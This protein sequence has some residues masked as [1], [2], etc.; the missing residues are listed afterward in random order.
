MPFTKAAELKKEYTDRINS[1]NKDTANELKQKQKDI[2]GEKDKEAKARMQRE[3]KEWQSGRASELKQI[4]TDQSN[5]YKDVTNEYTNRI[6]ELDTEI[7]EKQA[8]R[9]FETD[10]YK[11]GYTGFSSDIK[12]DDL[13][14]L[15]KGFDTEIGKQKKEADSAK[16]ALDAA[17][18]TGIQ[19]LIDRAQDMYNQQQGL[20]RSYRNR[21]Q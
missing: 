19:S 14:A 2:A 21:S 6:K 18:K 1:F 16:Q 20:R 13:T 3:L 8:L 17:K 10:V 11:K 7:K 4:Q 5:A 12:G 15:N 9:N